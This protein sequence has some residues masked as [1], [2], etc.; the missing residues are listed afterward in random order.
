MIDP[1]D[2]DEGRKVI[3]TGGAGEQETGIVSSWN[4]HAVFV[5]YQSNYSPFQYKLQPQATN[6]EDLRW[7]NEDQKDT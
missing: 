7:F 3:Y 1:Q 2:G 4:D 5:R 6:R